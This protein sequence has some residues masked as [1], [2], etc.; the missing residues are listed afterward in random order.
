MTKA[1]APRALVIRA[2]GT[3]CD[4]ELCRAFQAAGAAPELIH[5]D[6]LIARPAELDRF[7]LLGFPGGFSFGDDIASGR[8]FAMKVRT[9]LY[10]ALREALARGALA[11]GVCNGFQVLVQV[12]LLPGPAPGQDWPADQPPA[13]S[14]ALTDNQDA[15]FHDR[16]V[17]VTYEPRSVCVWTRGLDEPPPLP[18][19][20]RHMIGALAQRDPHALA[21]RAAG[22]MLPVAHGEGRLIA[23]DPGVISALERGGQ[24][25][26][27]YT[28]NFNGSTGAI[29]GVCDASGRVLGLMPHPERF[30]EWTRHPAWTRLDPQVR[31]RATPGL[32]LFRNA[33]EAAAGQLA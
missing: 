13:Q 17:G 30:L 14:L 29:A 8:I 25:A 16:W 11:I 19:R 20:D 31:S 6:R 2:A 7:D 9:A 10:P 28:D 5:L 27:R 32:R 15:R 24:V 26:V 33:V 3:N 21:A 4:A 22:A 23:A 1:E 12:G 18:E